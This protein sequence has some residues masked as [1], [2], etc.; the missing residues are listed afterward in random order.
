VGEKEAFQKLCASF[1]TG[2][3]TYDLMAMQR[4]KKKKKD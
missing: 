1:S 2:K 3:A 4:P